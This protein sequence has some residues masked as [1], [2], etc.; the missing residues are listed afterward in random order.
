MASVFPGFVDT[1]SS[2]PRPTISV[3]GLSSTFF[4]MPRVP[5][6]VPFGAGGGMST[7]S[8]NMQNFGTGAS[9]SNFAP[10]NTTMVAVFSKRFPKDNCHVQDLCF[11]DR[12]STGPYS[13]L[14][15]NSEVAS[16]PEMN[17]YLASL[18][19][20]KK[21]GI[22]TTAEPLL[23]DFAFGGTQQTEHPSDYKENEMETTF[24]VGR[25][26]RTNAITRAYAPAM[27]NQSEELMKKQYFLVIRRNLREID[28]I[29][30]KSRP[31]PC[32][33]SSSSSSPSV[34]AEAEYAV[35]FPY[36]WGFYP[37]SS[38]VE[39]SPW[40]YRDDDST[41]SCMLIGTTVDVDDNNVMSQ[42][43]AKEMQKAVS[44]VHNVFVSDRAYVE[45]TSRASMPYC[46][47][48]LGC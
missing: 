44:G 46:D 3:G 25:R 5:F 21:Y 27:Q 22:F 37:Y 36:Y 26:A 39:P 13:G 48:F 38:S 6:S 16:V 8:D 23:N 43:E 31:L 1:L 7:F 15:I 19:G 12:Y 28:T 10:I 47:I 24:T 20:R 2:R 11:I 17:R 45:I 18:D 42:E 4:D 29:P 33:S 34:E 14:K 32:A 9:T 30:T 40:L 35:E 41:G